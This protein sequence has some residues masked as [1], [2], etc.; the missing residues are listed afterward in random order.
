MTLDEIRASTAAFLRP[1][2]VAPVIR[3]DPQY[4][5]DVARQNPDK[6]GFPVTV[7]GT[8]TR[9]PRLAFLAFLGE[10]VIEESSG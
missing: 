2:D 4:I 5:R 9:I 10:P 7:M 8:R 3:C 1:V 6:L